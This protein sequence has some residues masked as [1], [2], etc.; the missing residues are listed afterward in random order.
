[1]KKNLEMPLILDKYNKY[2]KG[3]DYSTQELPTIPIRTIFKALEKY[4]HLF[5]IVI[6]NLY[7][8]YKL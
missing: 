1:M 6:F 3:V 5:E 4:I 8:L 2:M 7:V